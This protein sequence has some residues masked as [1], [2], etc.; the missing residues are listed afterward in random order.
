MA[1]PTT[2]PRFFFIHV[3]KTAG[4]SLR[5][6][7]R[8]QFPSPQVYPDPDIDANMQQAYSS[9]EYLWSLPAERRRQI[10]AYSGHFP[11]IAVERFDP[12]LVTLTL[13]R[14]PIDRSI[15]YLK[16]CTHY[17][18]QHKGMPLEQIYE[19]QFVF[20]F[21]IRNFQTKMFSMR[22][23]DELKN[24]ME[25]IDIDEER[26]ALAKRNLERVDVLGLTEHIGDFAETMAQ[27]F[28]WQMETDT[29]VNAARGDFEVP[30]SLIERI[31]TDNAADVA[32]YDHGCHLL[33]SLAGE[34]A[35]A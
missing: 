1:D 16:H 3:M 18:P 25:V 30:Q 15:S 27:R 11:W 32:L 19:D 31:A 5:F 24:C 22:E 35:K 9:I 7:L 21:F 10:R 20:Q 8:A 33:A 6:Q 4:W 28:G 29:T 23:G 34:S 17:H 2:E 12:S 13:L 14:E 26:L